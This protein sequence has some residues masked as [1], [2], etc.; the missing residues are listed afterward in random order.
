MTQQPRFQKHKEKKKK[1]VQGFSWK[2]VLNSRNQSERT[3]S[4]P[5]SYARLC[6]KPPHLVGM[7]DPGRASCLDAGAGVMEGQGPGEQLDSRLLH[8][9]LL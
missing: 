5:G 6:A 7:T 2:H 3:S 9:C 1:H 4:C 8:F